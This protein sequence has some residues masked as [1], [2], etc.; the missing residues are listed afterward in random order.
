MDV[1]EEEERERER[2]RNMSRKLDQTSIHMFV[3]LLRLLQVN[4]LRQMI[5]M[6][7]FLLLP[8]QLPAVVV[9]AAL[10]LI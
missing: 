1:V 6:H 8:S 4:S 7:F 3:L 10:S 5:E 2:E 9:V